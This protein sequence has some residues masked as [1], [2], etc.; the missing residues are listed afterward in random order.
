M[1]VSIISDMAVRYEGERYYKG[2][3]LVIKKEYFNAAIM[4]ELEETKE[5]VVEETKVEEE[6]KAAPKKAATTKAKKETE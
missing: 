5:E 3:E 4:K 2:D 6:V 1:K